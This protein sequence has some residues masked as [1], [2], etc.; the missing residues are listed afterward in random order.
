MM[1]IGAWLT[2]TGVSAL[3]GACSGQTIL[4]N[5]AGGK[6]GAGEP[7]ATQ[8]GASGAHDVPVHIGGG[9]EAGGAPGGIGVAMGEAGKTPASEGGAGPEGGNGGNGT[10]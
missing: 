10:Q 6:G 8:A 3:L 1:R 4:A 9:P 5:A 2:L 7:T